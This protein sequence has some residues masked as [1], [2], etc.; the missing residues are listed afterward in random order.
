MLC[1]SDM[2][3]TPFQPSASKLDLSRANYQSTDATALR[4]STRSAWG[5]F[6]HS[7]FLTRA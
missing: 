5:R 6:C 4:T 7:I 1:I 3:K 2:R